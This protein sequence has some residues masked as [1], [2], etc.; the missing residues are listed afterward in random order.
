[1]NI[2]D[3]KTRPAHYGIFVNNHNASV[4]W[5]KEHL[6]CTIINSFV[7]GNYKGTYMRGGNFEI[8]I[9]EDTA[10]AKQ[11]SPI[12]AN[13]AHIAFWVDD[14]EGRYQ[15]VKQKG[16]TIVIELMTNPVINRKFFHFMDL[17]GHV[18][19]LIQPV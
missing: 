4:E 16:I 3:I 17:D 6:G 5:Y 8:E 12:I 7:F 18:I 14:I 19:E 1:M 9:L 2:L 15:S 11:V 10:A 13:K